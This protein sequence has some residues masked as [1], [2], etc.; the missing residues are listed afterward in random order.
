MRFSKALLRCFAFIDLSRWLA[1]ISTRYR[2]RQLPA[3]TM[4]RRD[5][6]DMESVST[7]NKDKLYRVT[8]DETHQVTPWRHPRRSTKRWTVRPT[9]IYR[10][11]ETLHLSREVFLKAMKIGHLKKHQ[12]EVRGKTLISK[13]YSCS[14]SIGFLCL[15]KPS[16]VAKECVQN[17]PVIF[18][19]PQ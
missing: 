8:G 17:V 7:D 14:L 3:I 11:Q 1:F 12:T 6:L 18:L 10:K 16:F 5:V 13:D 19:H 9:A 4:A 2:T 15:T